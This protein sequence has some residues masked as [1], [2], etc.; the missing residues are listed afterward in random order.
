MV[1]PF[2]TSFECPLSDVINRTVLKTEKA[3][4]VTVG[5]S[6]ILLLPGKS[7]ERRARSSEG[8]HDEIYLILGHSIGFQRDTLS[9]N[10]P[11]YT[12]IE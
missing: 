8:V 4:R 12:V 9:R 1:A 7:Q 10:Q 2:R 3:I 5:A 6:G 11:E